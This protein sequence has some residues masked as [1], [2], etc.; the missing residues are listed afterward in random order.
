MHVIDSYCAFSLLKTGVEKLFFYQELL[1]MNRILDFPAA[2]GSIYYD[3]IRK[4]MVPGKILL[5][6]L[7]VSLMV[8]VN[9]K[10]HVSS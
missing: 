3:V 4:M 2:L 6:I 7:K 9:T 5:Y 1:K 10:F 8:H